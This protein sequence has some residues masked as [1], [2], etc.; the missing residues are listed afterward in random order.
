MSLTHKAKINNTQLG[1]WL[2]MNMLAVETGI[3]S[4]CMPRQES[5]NCTVEKIQ[6]IFKFYMASSIQCSVS[7]T[8]RKILKENLQIFPSL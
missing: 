6:M 8:K 4:A 1:S 5:Y 3:G 2:K 7:W